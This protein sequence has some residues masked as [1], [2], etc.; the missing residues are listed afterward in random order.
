MKK[1]IILFLLIAPI[2]SQ[3]QKLTIQ[4]TVDYINSAF[5]KNSYAYFLELSNDGII[6]IYRDKKDNP[7][8]PYLSKMSMHWSEVTFGKNSNSSPLQI[9]FNCKKTSESSYFQP[10]CI[11]VIGRLVPGNFQNNYIFIKD[12]YSNDKLH[13]ALTYLRS[14]LEL[15]DDYN[16]NDDDPFAPENFIQKKSTVLN[17]NESENI[18]LETLNGV[19]KVWIK[20]GTLNKHFVLDSGASEISLSKSTERELIANG[21]IEKEDYIES[22]LYR[23]ADGSIIKCR[24]LVI[25]EMTIGNYKIKNVRASIGVSDSPLLLGRSFLDNFKKWSIDNQNKKLILEK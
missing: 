14:E 20:I 4:E 22:A 11:T 19:Y 21:I 12:K 18:D 8:F 7:K 1:L 10:S 6:S 24:R 23:I 16:R 25:P 3:A 13:N 5:A 9:T 17:G 2:F 15:S